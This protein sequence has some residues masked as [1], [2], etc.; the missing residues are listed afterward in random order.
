MST[1]SE[2]ALVKA[3]NFDEDTQDKLE[4]LCDEAIA[5][6]DFDEEKNSK[7]IKILNAVLEEY[8][9]ALCTAKSYKIDAIGFDISWIRGTFAKHCNRIKETTEKINK[10]IDAFRQKQ[11]KIQDCINFIASKGIDKRTFKLLLNNFKSNYRNEYGEECSNFITFEQFATFIYKH[12]E[13]IN[14]IEQCVKD[15]DDSDDINIEPF[16]RCMYY[17][18]I[19]E[20]FKFTVIADE[21]GD[22]CC[23]YAK[24]IQFNNAPNKYITGYRLDF[25]INKLKSSIPYLN[26]LMT[27]ITVLDIDNELY[28]LANEQG[29]CKYK[30]KQNKSIVN[31]ENALEDVICTYVETA[32]KGL[33]IYCL[34]KTFE[35]IY[36]NPS[37]IDYVIQSK[38]K[39]FTS[40]DIDIDIRRFQESSSSYIMLPYSVAD[41]VKKH[42]KAEYTHR[43]AYKPSANIIYD[44]PFATLLNEVFDAVRTEENTESL[45]KTIRELTEER[46]TNFTLS[47]NEFQETTGV[48][49]CI[50]FEMNDVDIFTS[51][52]S[53]S[54]GESVVNKIIDMLPTIEDKPNEESADGAYHCH[55]GDHIVFK[56][57]I[58]ICSLPSFELAR[59]LIDALN[60]RKI[61]STTS[62][63]ELCKE[64]GDE[65]TYE[66]D[67]SQLHTLRSA[68]YEIT[69]NMSIY[70]LLNNRRHMPSDDVKLKE[71]ELTINETKYKVTS[72]TDYMYIYKKIESLYG[73][74][75]RFDNDIRIIK[76]HAYNQN[77]YKQASKQ[78]SLKGEVDAITSEYKDALVALLTWHDEA[79]EELEYAEQ[80]RMKKF[81]RSPWQ[82]T[83]NFTYASVLELITKGFYWYNMDV[84]YADLSRIA[85]KT[86]TTGNW[87]LHTVQEP[88]A[89]KTDAAFR[90]DVFEAIEA[91]N[92]PS[93]YKDNFKI[94]SVRSIVTAIRFHDLQPEDDKDHT[95]TLFS[96]FRIKPT[97]TN[98]QYKEDL[99]LLD[100]YFDFVKNGICAG[101]EQDYKTVM[102][103]LAFV[104]KY[105]GKKTKQMLIFR[106]KQGVG[107]NTFITPIKLIMGKLYCNDNETIDHVAGKFNTA[108]IGKLII[109]I[110]ELADMFDKKGDNLGKYTQ[111]INR[112]VTEQDQPIEPKGENAVTMETPTNL[113]LFTNSRHVFETK[114]DTRRFIYITC[115]SKYIGNKKAFNELY[116]LYENPRF[117]AALHR[118]FLLRDVSENAFT[119]HIDNDETIQIK[120]Q[121]VDSVRDA[122]YA[123][124]KYSD[125][126]TILKSDLETYFANMTAYISFKKEAEFINAIVNP[127]WCEPGNY[128]KSSN[129]NWCRRQERDEKGKKRDVIYCK[130]QDNNYYKQRE[131]LRDAWLEDVVTY[132]KDYVNDLSKIVFSFGRIELNEVYNG[133]TA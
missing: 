60:E 109:V 32:S 79:T 63:A 59:R 41:K 125:D 96:G 76:Q 6:Y 77:H 45:N 121:S 85:I 17:Y 16:N 20:Y 84:M 61:I 65:K 62:Y 132:R 114:D 42:D 52:D 50:D 116:E 72:M 83:S 104:L 67:L 56:L 29:W 106:S 57:L 14:S 99:K 73:S 18:V 54:I 15:I 53:K 30:P 13:Y 38:N 119:E 112:A 124:I 105:P 43:G 48:D 130:L 7:D 118:W 9:Q 21:F 5:Y 12:Q 25:N 87:L 103:W 91:A 39:V 51:D 90:K 64:Y 129:K 78:N 22:P 35:E 4:I 26:M 80:K 113:M 126:H 40:D 69:K 101:N 110:N 68:L 75:R 19:D 128:A 115:S 122:V 81:K 33:H 34:D 28:E 36:N 89:T 58:S 70:N 31:I 37:C 2:Q 47:F 86:E 82:T 1:T 98:K 93:Y 66:Q 88:G 100:P 3:L 74:A 120:V 27:H 49:E 133:E 24:G 117:L 127:G 107:K 8:M 44:I 94:F 10:R 123:F 92:M 102:D 11:D 97:T 71:L 46:N 131:A 55:G 108:L 23:N 95:A 111:G